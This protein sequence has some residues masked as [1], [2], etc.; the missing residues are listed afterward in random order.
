[1]SHG[2]Y[3]K[4]MK[5]II[6]RRHV[7][8]YRELGIPA[9]Q[10]PNGTDY[11]TLLDLEAIA[12]ALHGRDFAAWMLAKKEP[13]EMLFRLADEER[14]RAAARQGIRRVAPFRARIAREPQ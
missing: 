1:M 3:N 4:A 6:R 14:R 9:V 10:D 13:L 5:R 11:Y 8:L 12:T 2:A 7:A